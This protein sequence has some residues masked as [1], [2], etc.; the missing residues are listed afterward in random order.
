MVLPMKESDVIPQGRGRMNNDIV[1]ASIR[2]AAPVNEMSLAEEFLTL[3][4][5][6]GSSDDEDSD[7]M[8]FNLNG[9]NAGR[10]VVTASD[11]EMRGR[12]SCIGRAPNSTEHCTAGWQ[13]LKNSS[14]ANCSPSTDDCIVPRT[15]MKGQSPGGFETLAG[16]FDRA[17][18]FRSLSP[19][20][21]NYPP[22]DDDPQCQS[23]DPNLLPQ[24]EVRSTR[25]SDSDRTPSGR[26]SESSISDRNYSPDYLKNI[27]AHWPTDSVSSSRHACD[28]VS[29]IPSDEQSLQLSTLLKPNLFDPSWSTAEQIVPVDEVTVPSGDPVPSSRCSHTAG[30]PPESNCSNKSCTSVDSAKA[31]DPVKRSTC[32]SDIETTLPYMNWDYLEEQLQKAL[33]KEQVSQV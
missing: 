7:S 2:G 9:G 30:V 29:D 33:E 5:R 26:T 27:S 13:S 14:D 16:R 8:S 3:Q 18:S 12:G 1:G 28:H 21:T 15:G 10:A 17:C 20:N 22:C 24:S 4:H 25:L 31:C 23:A 11:A 32:M 19:F 6:N